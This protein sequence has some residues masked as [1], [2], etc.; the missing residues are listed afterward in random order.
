MTRSLWLQLAAMEH[1]M[2]QMIEQ[3][4]TLTETVQQ[5]QIQIQQQVQAHA[6][7]AQQAQALSLC[8]ASLEALLT[9]ISDGMK[10]SKTMS[11]KSVKEPKPV[12]EREGE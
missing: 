2:Q 8:A 3:I 12:C 11:E 10:H 4:Q 1:M 7:Q 9:S 6:S 5:Q